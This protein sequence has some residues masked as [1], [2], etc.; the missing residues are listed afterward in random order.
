[1]EEKDFVSKETI[2]TAAS[3]AGNL[4]AGITSVL[5]SLINTGAKGITFVGAQVGKALQRS[6][7]NAN[8]VEDLANNQVPKKSV[9]E[10]QEELQIL[11]LQA[12]IRELKGK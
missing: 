5:G 7:R 12:R 4:A 8:V 9:E 2:Q 6:Q 1:M 3:G 10:L 11:E